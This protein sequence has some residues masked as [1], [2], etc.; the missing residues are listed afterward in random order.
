MLEQRVI[1]FYRRLLL[2]DKLTLGYLI[3]APLLFAIMDWHLP[4]LHKM[5]VVHPLMI[6]AVLALIA[7]EAHLPR[8]VRWLRYVYPLIGFSFFFGMITKGVNLFFPFWLEPYLIRADIWLYGKH[9]WQFFAEHLNFFEVEFL[10]AAYW[11][12]YVLFPMITL[13]HYARGVRTGN[14]LAP[15]QAIDSVMSRLAISLFSCYVLFM[16]LPARGPHHV[17]HLSDQHLFTGGFFWHLVL[18]IQGQAKVVGAAFPSAHVAAAW[19]LY[20]TLR[21]DFP[22]MYW[23]LLPLMLALTVSVFALQYHFTMDA[24][25]GL[26]LPILI[27][28]VWCRFAGKRRDAGTSRL[29]NRDK[30]LLGKLPCRV[31]EFVHSNSHE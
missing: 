4:V 1:T 31:T 27:E 21:R 29:S 26:L 23:S 12:Y 15:G 14:S 17:F 22:K 6:L 18:A 2:F 16:L 24:V 3:L 25:A 20:L 30:M 11:S 10:A 5:A 7:L 13:M 28:V 19:T 9:G 8:G